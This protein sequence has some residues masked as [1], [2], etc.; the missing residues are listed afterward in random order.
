MAKRHPGRAVWEERVKRW[1][2]SGMS[3][4]AFAAEHGFNAK[5]LGYWR[6]KLDQARG[7][8]GERTTK[9]AKQSKS[10][11]LEAGAPVMSFVELSHP[12][13]AREV[14]FEIEFRSGH[15]VHVPVEF[16]ATAL[17]RL[18]EVMEG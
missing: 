17:A 15:R 10:E 2:A 7:S 9:A 16:E 18:L 13:P 11:Q 1:R 6:W 8:G 12:A 14:R 3:Q 5:T 4:R